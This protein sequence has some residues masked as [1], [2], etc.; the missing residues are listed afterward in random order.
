MKTYGITVTPAAGWEASTRQ[1]RAVVAAKSQKAAVEAFQ[2]AGL[3]NLTLHHFRNY[4]SES[5]N[6]VEVQVTGS[7][8]GVVFWCPDRFTSVP[9]Y[10]PVEVD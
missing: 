1:V 7:R 8:P 5:A 4:G 3:S 9:D 10:R 6:A 2:A